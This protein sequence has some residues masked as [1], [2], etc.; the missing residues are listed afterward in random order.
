LD[1]KAGTSH[2]HSIAN[3]S[4]QLGTWIERHHLH[5]HTHT[6]SPTSPISKRQWMAKRI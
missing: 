2:T 1:G 6:R 4:M 5:T 3:V